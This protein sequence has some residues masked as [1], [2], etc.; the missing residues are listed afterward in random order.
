MGNL[1]TKLSAEAGMKTAPR[2]AT[3]GFK[4]A[5]ICA[6]NADVHQR[7]ALSQSV[8]YTAT[9]TGAKKLH[10]L[11]W[12]SVGRSVQM[13]SPETDRKRYNSRWFNPNA[14][15][16]SKPRIRPILWT[17]VIPTSI[18]IKTT[19]FCA[20]SATY[21]STRDVRNRTQ[22]AHDCTLCD[23]GCAHYLAILN[24]HG[25]MF[26]FFILFKAFSDQ[27]CFL[28]LWNW[29]FWLSIIRFL[30]CA[31][32]L[33]IIKYIFVFIKIYS[34]KTALNTAVVLPAS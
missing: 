10:S 18:I 14:I 22:S 28:K 29:G 9:S 21:S 8:R 3:A 31:S 5:R 11:A 12:R 15:L 32:T 16:I 6:F 26:F 13:Y 4:S 25:N 27:L 34:N 1:F 24:E 2:I 17:K 30:C 33:T 20:S 19:R 7:Q 23:D